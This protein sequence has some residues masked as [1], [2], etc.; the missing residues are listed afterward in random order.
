MAI[1]VGVL[2]VVLALLT[3]ISPLRKPVTLPVQER[4]EMKSSGGAKLF[5]LIVV[6]AT[7]VLYVLFW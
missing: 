2:V 7:A 5:G 1:T 3:A 4:F 6:A